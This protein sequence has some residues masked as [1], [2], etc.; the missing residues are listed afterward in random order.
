MTVVVIRNSFLCH[1][2]SDYR[3]NKNPDNSKSLVKENIPLQERNFI[4]KYIQFHTVDDM[5]TIY[6][7]GEMNNIILYKGIK[8]TRD[9][10]TAGGNTTTKNPSNQND[11]SFHS[12]YRLLSV[13]KE[14]LDINGNNNYVFYTLHFP[15]SSCFTDIEN[16]YKQFQQQSESKELDISAKKPSYIHSNFP[17]LDQPKKKYLDINHPSN[18]LTP[19]NFKM[20]VWGTSNLEFIPKEKNHIQD[21]LLLFSFQWDQDWEHFKLI[22]Q[23]DSNNFKVEIVGGK[24][25]RDDFRSIE[26]WNAFLKDKTTPE[27]TKEFGEILSSSRV[28]DEENLKG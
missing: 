14:S 13:I 27:E 16:F 9:F 18:P 7:D 2:E 6:Q 11:N 24:V 3:C 5:T 4:N 23:A 8:T 22:K 28:Y 10:N 17:P 12:E 21:L 20:G 26:P 15:C 1:S 19:R 25:S